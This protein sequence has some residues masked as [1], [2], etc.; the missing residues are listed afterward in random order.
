MVYFGM[1]VVSEAGHPALGAVLKIDNV[2]GDKLIWCHF[3]GVA[4]SCQHF[5]LK[6]P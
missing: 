6:R 4:V 5:S 2:N 1:L 3:C